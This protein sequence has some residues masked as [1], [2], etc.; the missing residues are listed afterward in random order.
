MSVPPAGSPSRTLPDWFLRGLAAAPYRPALRIGGESWTYQE[1]H[2]T[3][4]IWAGTLLAAKGSPGA[5]GVLAGRTFEARVGILAALYAGAAVVPLSPDFPV[6]RTAAMAEAAALDAVIADRW[7][8]QIAAES[9]ALFAGMPI[10]VPDPETAIAARG[11]RPDPAQALTSPVPCR[12]EDIAYVLF[13]SGSTGRPKGVPVTHANVDHFL[14]VNHER[15]ALTTED[16]L[17][18]TFDTTFDLAMFDLFMAWGA[19]AASVSTP[20]QVLADLPR[21]VR[22]Q[23]LTVWFSVPSAIPIVRRR[24]G[25]TERSMPS[26][27]WSLFCGEPLTGRAATD[28]QLA[29]D[30]STVENLYGPTELTI[31]CS[32]YRWQP[33]HSREV[34]VNDIV[35]IGKLYPGLAGILLGEDGAVT[36]EQGELCVAGD[37]VF[38]GYLD[39]ADDTGRF[40]D[41]AGRRW[42]RTGD[43]VRRMAGAGLAYLGRVDH[44]VKIRGNRVEPAEIEV[45][46]RGELGVDDAVAVEFAHDGRGELALFYVG[47]PLPTQAVTDRLADVLPWEM[48]PRWTWALP[49]FPLNA[50]RKVDRRALAELAANWSHQPTPVPKTTQDMPRGK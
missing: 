34:C 33:D 43:L 42:Y 47:D 44:Q 21:F 14:A 27:R 29:A 9:A 39:P 32:A 7:G 17:S 50:N 11:V 12:A 31:A 49:E 18:Q 8:L 20:P 38:A 4:L 15:Y 37:Q 24:G 45:V 36:T 5:V 16:V 46:A 40:V 23:G 3:A 1:I 26:L 6:R 13:T 48:V 25:L 19:G 28:W 30:K 41:H 35:P 22:D 10:L 2:Q